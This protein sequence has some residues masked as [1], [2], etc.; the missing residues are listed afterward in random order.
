MVFA[1]GCC[2]I[3]MVTI[4][5]IMIDEHHL[6]QDLRVTTGKDNV[7]TSGRYKPLINKQWVTYGL[8]N[9]LNL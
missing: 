8:F 4:R 2:R 3:N 9:A 6:Q 5:E 1:D 7:H